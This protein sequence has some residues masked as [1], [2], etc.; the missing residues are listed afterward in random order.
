MTVLIPSLRQK[1]SIFVIPR[2]MLSCLTILTSV[3]R[4]E[5]CRE[6]C[7]RRNVSCR[8][9]WLRLKNLVT[10]YSLVAQMVRWLLVPVVE[11]PEESCRMNRVFSVFL[12][13]A[14]N[15]N[16]NLQMKT[17]EKCAR[18]HKQMWCLGDGWALRR[19]RPSFGPSCQDGGESRQDGVCDVVPRSAAAE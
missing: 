4:F 18:Q 14:R 3:K 17:I 12:F 8:C 1:D 15:G 5:Q 10:N 16:G 2:A 19:V 6:V 13:V 9:E 11:P 7:P